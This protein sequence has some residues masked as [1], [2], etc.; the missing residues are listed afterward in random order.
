MK[1]KDDIVFWGDISIVALEAI[2]SQQ[3][4]VN[5]TQYKNVR[6]AAEKVIE[7]VMKNGITKEVLQSIVAKFMDV[8][9]H[10]ANSDICREAPVEFVPATLVALCVQNFTEEDIGDA[11]F[12]DLIA[13]AYSY[14]TGLNVN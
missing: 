13:G 10:Y 9:Q 11:D 7:M 4:D 6:A 2:M 5:S 3:G 8:R 14:L 1:C 12:Q